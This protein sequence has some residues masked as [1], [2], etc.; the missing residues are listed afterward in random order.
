MKRYRLIEYDGD[1]QRIVDV[2]VRSLQGSYNCA[3]LTITAAPTTPTPR[4]LHE[5]QR[6][7]DQPVQG[8]LGKHDAGVPGD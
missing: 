3:N 2:W 4:Q 6:A 5:L 7:K 8:W 1:E